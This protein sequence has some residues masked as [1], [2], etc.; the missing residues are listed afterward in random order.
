MPTD[1]A[2]AEVEELKSVLNEAKLIIST[3]YRGLN[4]T[5]LSGL[6]RAIREAGGSYRVAKNS[7]V[8]IAS[9]EID[10]PEISEI[11]VGPTGF[12]LSIDDPV[13]PTRAL[14]AH[15]TENRLDVVVN[16][17]YLE[18]QLVDA[19]RVKYLSTLPGR[20][21]LVAKLLGQMNAPVANLV[22]VLSATLRGFMTVIQAHIDQGGNAGGAEEPPV[23][24]AE[25]EA[26]DEEPVAEAEAEATEEEPEAAD[27]EPV[28]EAEAEATEE[29]PEAADE[30]PVAEAEAE[31]TEDE[32][33]AADEEPVAEAEAEA[34]EDEPAE[35]PKVADEEPVAEAEAETTEEEAPEQAE[36]SAEETG[37]ADED[38][39]AE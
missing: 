38:K 36:E 19:D 10:R 22:G 25:P 5:E 32:P 28:A 39:P 16:G 14:M 37:E 27:E 31:A 9:E 34:T 1:K 12:V 17:A 13:G 29:E 23:A 33:E 2:I 35:E 4:V 11:V 18:G 6:R 26:A 7:L 21:E 30:E 15:I 8:K 3:D 20:E 24:E